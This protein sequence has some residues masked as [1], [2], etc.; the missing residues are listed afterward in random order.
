M[1]QNGL[2]MPV[3]YDG[4]IPWDQ[5]IFLYEVAASMNGWTSDQTKLAN[6]LIFSLRG[7][8]LSL[9][10]TLD[11]ETRK[12]YDALKVKLNEV[13]CPEDTLDMLIAQLEQ[14]K[15]KDDETLI[16]LKV[17]IHKLVC[18]VYPG[19]DAA[20]LERHARVAFLKAISGT[21]YGEKT[22]DAQPQTLDE[23]LQKAQFFEQRELASRPAFHSFESCA[24]SVCSVE[25]EAAAEPRQKKVKPKCYKCGEKGHLKSNCPKRQ[26]S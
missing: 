17:D 6:M 26:K 3:V 12:D 13:L 9:C 2:I 21:G 4:T 14:R 20:S 11:E 25:M 7:H 8:A 15:R 22:I 19:M 5:W 23:A 24:S 16:D 18:K 1:S 10:L